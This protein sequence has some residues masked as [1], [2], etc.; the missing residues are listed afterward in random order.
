MRTFS[1]PPPPRVTTSDY[2]VPPL[3]VFEAYHAA[4]QLAHPCTRTV[5]SVIMRR[6]S[7]LRRAGDSWAEIARCCGLSPLAPRAIYARM[8]EHLK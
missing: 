8:P 6:I 7:M 4:F 1:G 5:S 2:A 3:P